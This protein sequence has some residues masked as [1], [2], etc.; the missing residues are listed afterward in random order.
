MLGKSIHEGAPAQYLYRSIHMLTVTR[1]HMRV[2]CVLRGKKY[3]RLRT[4][5]EAEKALHKYE[6]FVVVSKNFP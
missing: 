5:H 1:P 3:P 2:R 4:A 6:P